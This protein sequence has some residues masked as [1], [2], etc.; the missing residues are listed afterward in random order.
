MM[1]ACQQSIN[2]GVYDR[3]QQDDGVIERL[4]QQDDD[5]VVRWY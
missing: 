2:L 5:V 1:Y 3:Y 4:Y